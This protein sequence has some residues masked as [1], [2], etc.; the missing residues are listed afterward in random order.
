MKKSKFK[1]YMMPT[2]KRRKWRF[3]GPI[4]LV[5]IV[6]ILVG[7]WIYFPIEFSVGLHGTGEVREAE[8]TELMQEPAAK[9][10][11]FS[12]L[13]QYS[14]VQNGGKVQQKNV[15]SENTDSYYQY[16]T[17][18]LITGY[19][20]YTTYGGWTDWTTC[21]QSSSP[22]GLIV[23][24]CLVSEQD[25][26]AYL[27]NMKGT[28]GVSSIDVKA[29]LYTAEG[30]LDYQA[31]TDLLIRGDSEELTYAEAAAIYVLIRDNDL[32]GYCDQT[33][34]F[35]KREEGY[36]YV[37]SCTSEGVSLVR[38]WEDECP[39]VYAIDNL[40]FFFE[41][42]SDIYVEGIYKDFGFRCGYPERAAEWGEP[43]Q[44]G[45]GVVEREEYDVVVVYIRTNTKMIHVSF[46]STDPGSTD[47]RDADIGE[48][49]GPMYVIAN[50]SG[51]T[52]WAEEG[53]GYHYYTQLIN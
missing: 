37:Y 30:E 42:A 51:V 32:I 5:L 39:C 45:Y 19:H 20:Q 2:V 29:G 13:F 21:T 31:V 40:C 25:G 28:Y 7:L 35:A 18:M 8:I 44:I 49:I 9:P 15:N 36:T 50:K 24:G 46:T 33:A 48:E 47:Y 3:V 23:N 1:Y 17:K 53:D 12:N 38:T 41:D 16:A 14:A 11:F 10:G 26:Y 52:A 27:D 4:E 22:L 34:W 43:Q 6:A